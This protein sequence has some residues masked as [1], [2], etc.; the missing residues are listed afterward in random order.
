MRLD[1]YMGQQQVALVKVHAWEK[2]PLDSK[3]YYD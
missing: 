2:Q 3:N 1:N